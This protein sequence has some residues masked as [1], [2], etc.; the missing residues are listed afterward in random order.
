MQDDE[1]YQ[2]KITTEVPGTSLRGHTENKKFDGNR[3][4]EQQSE[5]CIVFRAVRVVRPH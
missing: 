1:D 3:S 2:D 5:D 4:L